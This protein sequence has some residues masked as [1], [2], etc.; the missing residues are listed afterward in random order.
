ML[1]RANLCR[2]KGDAANEGHDVSCG[3]GGNVLKPGFGGGCAV[4]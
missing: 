4:L 1:K 3:D 2:E